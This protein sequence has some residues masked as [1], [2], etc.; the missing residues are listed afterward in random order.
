MEKEIKLWNEW[1]EDQAV[2][3][4]A[5]W[6]DPQRSEIPTGRFGWIGYDYL[7]GKLKRKYGVSDGKYEDFMDWVAGGCEKFPGVKVKHEVI[8]PVSS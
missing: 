1:K 2:R 5:Y 8:T 4:E 6:K 7:E 3:K